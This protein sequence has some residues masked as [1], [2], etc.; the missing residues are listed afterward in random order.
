MIEL[1]RKVID[2]VEYVE[3]WKDVVGFEGYYMVS[4]FGRVKSLD[5]RNYDALG[6]LQNHKGKIINIQLSN[7][8]YG[9]CELNRHQKGIKFSIHRLVSIA[10]VDN[11]DNK[12]QVDHINGIK[13][14]NMSCNLRWCTALENC[15]YPISRKKRSI[16]MIGKNKGEK[17]FF[18]GKFGYLNKLSKEVVQYDSGMNII[19][20]YGSIRDAERKTGICRVGIGKTC[21][22]KRDSAG[23][24]K[25][26]FSD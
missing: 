17:S 4:S 6:R 7:R 3:E 19:N 14:D 10:F 13:T 18:F 9:R 8:G 15:G 21:N 5:R 25:W 24:F 23:G 16:A 12:P 2:G 11:P 20:K 1:L 26:K 22:G